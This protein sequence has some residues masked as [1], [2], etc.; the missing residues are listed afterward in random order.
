[1]NT[2]VMPGLPRQSIQE[3]LRLVRPAQ[4]PGKGYKQQLFP[5]IVADM[6]G[7]LPPVLRAFGLYEG[8][9][10]LEGARASIIEIVHLAAAAVDQRLLLSDAVKIE[11]RHLP[12]LSVR[13]KDCHVDETQIMSANT[14]IMT[15][16][17]IWA[18]LTLRC[19]LVVTGEKRA[20]PA[21][22]RVDRWEPHCQIFN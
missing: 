19:G 4:H 2:P 11:R 3:E 8:L 5:F 17:T 12:L 14:I 15:T 20:A 13:G 18:L 9:D 22:A 7:P 16:N 1:M 6:H 10:D 21:H